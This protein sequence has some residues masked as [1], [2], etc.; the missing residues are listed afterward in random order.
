M[1]LTRKGNR[2][3]L[4]EYELQRELAEQAATD[5]ASQLQIESL[6]HDGLN[7]AIKRALESVAQKSNGKEKAK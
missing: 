4:T 2:S 3:R 6:S 5:R 1:S 7:R